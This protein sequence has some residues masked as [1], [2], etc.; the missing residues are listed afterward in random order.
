MSAKRS[1]AKR[2]KTANRRLDGRRTLPAI[3]SP[4]APGGHGTDLA[5]LDAMTD[6]DIARGIANDPDAAPELDASWFAHARRGLAAV[7]KTRPPR[8]SIALRVAPDVLEFF[9]RDG[10]GYQSRMHA[11][12]RAYVDH[13]NAREG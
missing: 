6:A 3:P 13:Q 5:R 1:S 2:A 7:V 8:Q 9:K 12:L 10:A 4:V 11:V